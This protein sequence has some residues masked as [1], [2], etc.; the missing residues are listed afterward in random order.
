MY[1]FI[2]NPASCSG[3][4][5]SIW[6]QI[7]IELSR[8]NLSYQYAFTQKPGDAACIAASFSSDSPCT[9]IAVGGDG[10]ANEVLNGL[11]LKNKIC[12]G[13]IPTGSSND[14]ARGLGIPSDPLEALSCILDS[15]KFTFM[16]IGIIKDASHQKRFAVSSGIGFDAGICHEAFHSPVKSILNRFHLGRLTYTV[17]A[18]HQLFAVKRSPMKLT[19]DKKETFFFKKAYMAAIMNHPCEG[20][21]IHFC[22]DASCYDGAFDICIIEGLPRIAAAVVLLSVFRKKH[23]KSR[24]VHIFRCRTA[25]IKTKDFLPGHMDGE[26]FGICRDISV[27]VMNQKLCIISK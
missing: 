26:V 19:L 13:Y 21:G 5:R 3:K 23:T 12:F 17:I 20:G 9:I 22:P 6:T 14:L 10:T 16:D 7:K 24:H 4:G 8:R 25:R 2:V 11:C 15:P 18:V 1:Y 27:S